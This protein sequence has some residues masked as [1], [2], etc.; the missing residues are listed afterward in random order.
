MES[1]T[2]I[3][4]GARIEGTVRGQGAVEIAGAL[5]GTLSVTGGVRV[6]RGATV[7]ASVEAD[8]VSI[9]GTVR[10]SVTARKTASLGDGALLEGDLTAPM[11]TT[12]PTARVRGQLSM[13]I[14]PQRSTHPARYRG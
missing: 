2:L 14:E 8:E 13:D 6:R 10:G 1:A 5:E 11:V 3:S 12:A 9:H 4:Q 7:Q